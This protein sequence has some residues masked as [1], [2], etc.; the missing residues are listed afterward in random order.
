MMKHSP[1]LLFFSL[2]LAQG[3]PVGFMTHALPVILRTEGVS[4]A[5]IGGFGLLMLPWSCKVFWAPW[6]DRW[7]SQRW[8]HYRSWIMPLQLLSIVLLIAMAFF[9]IAQ[10][11]NTQYLLLFFIL[12]LS[13]NLVGATQDIATDGL[14]V[15]VLS[16]QEQHWGNSFQVIG[17]RLGFLIGGGA[18]LWGLDQTSWQGVF[19]L[20]AALI[21]MNSLPICTY[22][23]RAVQ[24]QQNAHSSEGT[25]R[26]TLA[27]F[28]QKP[29]LRAWCGVLLS[30]KVADGLMG[31][32]I[33]PMYVDM[34]LTYSQIGLYITILGAFA[35]LVGAA[36]MSCLLQYMTRSKALLCLSVL[37]IV[38]IFLYVMLAYA[39]EQGIDISST[40]V[41]SINAFEDA[42]AAM[43]LVV[44]LTIIMQYSRKAKAGTD[45]TLQVSIMATV[46]GGLYI[47]SGWFA[48]LFGYFY[49]LNWVVLLACFCLWPIYRWL[50]LVQPRL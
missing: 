2:Y 35:A 50:R 6:V 45:F 37:K 22:K 13:I 38:S 48:E 10:L 7:G 46:S 36:F 1:Y 23:E 18:V 3:L 28:W 26:S 15:R 19:L 21:L 41:Y 34:G 17:S 8:G 42:L 9:P 12:L 31:P 14:A 11:E 40:W 44:M 30:F 43:L 27:Y 25:W 33:K 39:F 4:L 29:E 32:V 16:Q 5:Q 47:V 20:L 49:Y 24:I